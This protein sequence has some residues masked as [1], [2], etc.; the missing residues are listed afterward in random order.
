MKKFC[1]PCGI[2]A[3][4]HAGRRHRRLFCSHRS[5][6]ASGFMAVFVFG[7]MLRQQ[8]NPLASRW[9]PAK[10]KSSPNLFFDHGVHHAPVHFYAS[11]VPGRFSVSWV[12]TCGGGVIVVTILML[13]A[14]AS[15]GFS[16]GAWPDPAWR[17]GALVSWYSC[18]WNAPRPAVISGSAG[19]PPAG[20]E[21]RQAAQNDRV[22]DLHCH[23]DGRS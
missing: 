5:F 9:N 12:N 14:R 20:H 21:Q 23:S 10:R 17:A 6:Q 7:I 11:G 18:C 13:V 8:G 4:R 1:F 2:C 16:C 15:H 19:W 22:G 3:G